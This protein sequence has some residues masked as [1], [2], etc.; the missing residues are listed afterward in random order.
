[1]AA[2][3]TAA[4]RKKLKVQEVRDELEA[5]GLPTEGT[6]AVLLERLEEA[7]AQEGLQEMP[8]EE[9]DEGGAEGGDEEDGGEAEVEE[10]TTLEPEG[11]D[12]AKGSGDKVGGTADFHGVEQ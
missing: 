5:R 8:E 12:D 11:Q 10:N 4:E 2:E 7:I 9:G 6:K 3:M 1:M